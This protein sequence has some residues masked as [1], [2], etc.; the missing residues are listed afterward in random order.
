MSKRSASLRRGAFAGLALLLVLP[1]AADDALRT[2]IRKQMRDDNYVLV[3]DHDGAHLYVFS[4]DGNGYCTQLARAGSPAD[5][6]SRSQSSDSRI[7]VR[8][9]AELS[10]VDS[11]AALNAALSMLTDPD[12]AVRE[13][14]VHAV[15]DHPSADRKTVIALARRDSSARVR[16]ALQ[17][18]LDEDD[19]DEE[20]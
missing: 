6:L 16:G 19:E 9:L 18:L 8:A 5:A 20:D 3:E 1:A 4:S 11:D 14:A 10:G 2:T 7:R 15:F 13:E 12:E 17:E